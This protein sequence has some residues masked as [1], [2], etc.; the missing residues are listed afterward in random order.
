MSKILIIPGNIQNAKSY[1][2]WDKLCELLKDHEI[3][4]IEGILPIT[5]IVDLVNWCDKWVSID[6]F[7]PHLCAYYD[8]KQGIVI[9][10]KSDPEIFGHKHNINLLKDRKYLKPQQFQWWREEKF[11]PEVFISPEEIIKNI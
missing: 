3:K 4:K 9:W 10:G 5:Q 8:L 7:V 6:S 1:P 2:H 11:D